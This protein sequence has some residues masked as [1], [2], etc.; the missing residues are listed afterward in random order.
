M[1]LFAAGLY[2]HQPILH[3]QITVQC[4]CLFPLILGLEGD[5]ELATGKS[6]A[7]TV[8]ASKKKGS[9]PSKALLDAKKR[10]GMFSFFFCNIDNYFNVVS[11]SFFGL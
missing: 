10:I 5:D 1:Q 2:N 9:L 7:S 6:T 8:V 4:T 11:L 3:L